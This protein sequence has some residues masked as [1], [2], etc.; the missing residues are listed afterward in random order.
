MCRRG[1]WADFY[2]CVYIRVT[3][4]CV[5]PAPT[6]AS[7]LFNSSISSVAAV[8]TPSGDSAVFGQGTEIQNYY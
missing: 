8:N 1:R 2:G 7:P 5:T 6:S 4:R 3:F